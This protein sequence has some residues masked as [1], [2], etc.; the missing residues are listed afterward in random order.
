MSDKPLVQQA[1]AD[2]LASLVLQMPQQNAMAFI[3][4]FWQTMSTEWYGIDRLRYVIY[5]SSLDS[6]SH[7]CIPLLPVVKY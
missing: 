1:L 5:Y 2:T 6:L 4:A 3:D 7:S